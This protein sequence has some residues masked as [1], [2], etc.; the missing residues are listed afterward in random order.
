MNVKQVN[1]RAIKPYGTDFDARPMPATQC[2][3]GTHL[4][5]AWVSAVAQAAEPVLDRRASKV[6]QAHEVF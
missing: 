3:P 5:V 4:P 6:D 1:K 2:A